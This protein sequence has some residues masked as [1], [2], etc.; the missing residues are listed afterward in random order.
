MLIRELLA[1][2][3]GWVPSFR[4]EKPMTPEQKAKFDK[5]VTFLKKQREAG[6]GLSAAHDALNKN[7]N[8]KE[9]W[10]PSSTPGPSEADKDYV[11][12]VYVKANVYDGK[13]YDYRV[14]DV[15]VVAPTGEEA[16]ALV[17]KH[18]AAALEQLHGRK[19]RVGRAE[20]TKY[21]IP[22][23]EPAEKNVFLDKPMTVKKCMISG[24]A[25]KNVLGKDGKLGSISASNGV[26]E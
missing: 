2:G 10:S 3:E 9:E 24:A 7:K 1:V 25:I 12:N 8:V 5:D 26:V 20:A 18:K 13:Y 6:K 4:K 19:I 21:L 16:I 15:R 22:H 14:A 17:K 23:S 11:W